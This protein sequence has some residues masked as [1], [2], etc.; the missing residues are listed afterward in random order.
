MD[1]LWCSSKCSDKSCPKNLLN[2]VD[3]GEQY[4][5]ADLKGRKQ[6][7]HV[8]I[9]SHKGVVK[10]IERG[11]AGH[12]ICSHWCRFR[13]NTLLI[14][15]DKRWVVSTVG[16]YMPPTVSSDGTLKLVDKIETIGAERW[17]ETMVFESSYDKYDDADVSKQIYPDQPW[18]VFGKTYEEAEETYGDLDIYANKMHERIVQEMIRKI[19]E[20][21]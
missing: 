7:P 5:S 9:V 11:W 2:R 21:R 1:T 19:K 17:Y 10:R 15:E 14:F 18:S 8:T 3:G 13:R 12:F 16:C 20:Q 6:C 4:R